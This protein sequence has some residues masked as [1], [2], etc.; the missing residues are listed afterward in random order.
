MG[1]SRG[2]GVRM[3][4]GILFLV[5]LACFSLSVQDAFR[6][7]AYEPFLLAENS[8]GGYPVFVADKLV[9]GWDG[10]DL[11]AGDRVLAIGGTDLRGAGP[12][13]W[14][15]AS[16]RFHGP[17]PRI[18]VE[19]ESSGRRV[20]ATVAAGTYRRFWPRF[21]A[22]I[23]FVGCAVFLSFWARRSPLVDSIILTNLLAGIFFSCAFAGNATES[24]LAI[25]THVASLA[26]AAPLSLRVVL[27]FPHGRPPQST[28][29]R[30]GP[31]AFS[32]LALFDASRFYGVPLSYEWGALG[33]AAVGLAYVS[34]AVVVGARTYLR[35][36]ARARRRMKWVFLASYVVTVPFTLAVAASAFDPRFGS[37]LALLI[38]VF[39]VLPIAVTVALVRFNLL[40]VDRLLGS[41]ATYTVLIVVVLTATLWAVPA[42]AE[43]V[44][45]STGVESTIAQMV[46]AFALALGLVRLHAWMRPGIDR[47]F[48]ADRYEFEK[49]VHE[50]MRDLSSCASPEE[51]AQ[52][53][54]QRLSGGLRLESLSL[55]LEVE[56]RM[57]PVFVEG[58]PV[59]SPI[60]RAS[61]LVAALQQGGRILSEE[62]SGSDPFDRAVLETLGAPVVLGIWGSG[63]LSGL[64]AFGPKKSG[65]VYTSTE[66]AL[67]AAVADKVGT[68]LARFDQDARLAASTRLQEKLRQYM[69]PHLADRLDRDEPIDLGER[70]LSILFSDLRNYTHYAQERPLDEV[71]STVTR[72]ARAVTSIV[73]R[74]GGSVVDFAGDGVMAVFGAP[75]DLPNKERAAVVAAL[76][77]IEEVGDLGTLKPGVGIAT[78]RAYVASVRAGGQLHWTALGD[79]TNLAS[80]I[81]GLTRDLD[82]WIVID[83]ATHA[84]AGAATRGFRPLGDVA[85]RGRSAAARLHALPMDPPPNTAT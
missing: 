37:V 10:P 81:Q 5:W 74:H 34:L 68:E 17:E 32:S 6:E 18:P 56:D 84:G 24:G 41:A 64:L 27:M 80:R 46:L 4:M 83:D 75:T 54:G 72:Y 1:G 25:F 71:Y 85:I 69:D 82:A 73:H 76:D 40:D 33:S 51:L 15:A 52:T 59:P 36:D 39:G 77:I 19:F 14:I 8:G 70:E 16:A 21:V 29:G 78:G 44:S 58:S 3:A 35:S 31:W 30:Y 12:A 7:T 63:R 13:T 79:T 26:L 49:G 9:R 55:F 65:D 38:S 22:A 45:V 50:L 57:A 53:A 23:A 66:T 42:L 2:V 43:V 60:P 67:L 11:V 61:P 62:T 20:E 48:F 47:V 28:W